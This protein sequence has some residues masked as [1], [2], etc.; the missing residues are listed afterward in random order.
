MPPPTTISIVNDFGNL[1]FDSIGDYKCVA[2]SYTI[3]SKDNYSLITNNDIITRTETGNLDI[4][5]DKEIITLTSNGNYSDAITIEA[6]NA[7]GGILQTAGTGG[8]DMTTTNGE[9]NLLSQGSDINIGVSPAGVPTS[10]QTQNLNLE[11][12]NN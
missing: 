5:S 11:S 9:I 10:Q 7:N 12:V 3:N 1:K 4:I 6:T 8:I 2:S